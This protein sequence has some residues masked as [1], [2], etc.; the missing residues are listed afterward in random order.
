MMTK[1]QEYFDSKVDR[2]LAKSFIYAIT[3]STFYLYN[4]YHKQLLVG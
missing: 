3:L 4:K 2:K 1:V